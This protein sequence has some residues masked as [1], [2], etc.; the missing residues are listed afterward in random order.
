MPSSPLPR[1]V[2]SICFIYVNSLL[3]D[4]GIDSKR[5][6]IIRSL[7][8]FPKQASLWKPILSVIRQK[9]LPSSNLMPDLRRPKSILVFYLMIIFLGANHKAG[10]FLGL[11]PFDSEFPPLASLHLISWETLKLVFSLSLF[12]NLLTSNLQCDYINLLKKESESEN[13][14]SG[15]QLF[16]TPRIVVCQAPLSMEYSRPEYCSGQSF[17]SP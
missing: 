14:S 2:L 8:Y 9:M 1:K 16:V 13:C 15:V 11:T 12:K 10:L 17:P 6:V 7:D 3:Y 5:R 4:S